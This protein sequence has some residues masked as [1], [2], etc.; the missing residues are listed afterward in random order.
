MH[1]GNFNSYAPTLTGT[2]ASGNWPINSVNVTGTVAMGNGGTGLTS[3]GTAGNVLTSVGG[4]WASAA[5]TGGGATG[6][7]GGALAGTYPNPTMGVNPNYYVTAGNGYG[8]EF[9]NSASY[10][11]T[12]GNGTNYQYGPVTDYSINTSMNSGSPGRGFT[13]GVY[14]TAP[15]AALSEGGNFQVAGTITAGGAISAAIDN[16][17]TWGNTGVRTEVRNDAG[18]SGAGIYSGFFNT[19]AP[20]PAGDWPPGASSWWHLLDVRHQN[21]AN[22]YAMQFA[23]G[24]FDQNLWF[25]KTN[26]SA[27]SAWSQ[28]LVGH[29]TQIYTVNPAC[30]NYNQNFEMANGNGS[31]QCISWN[32]YAGYY[33]CFSTTW[34]GSVSFNTQATNPGENSAYVLTT[35][36]TCPEAACSGNQYEP[37]CGQSAC[38]T[39]NFM[40]NGC[41]GNTGSSCATSPPNCTNTSQG[42]TAN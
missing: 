1:N 20:S 40:G 14:N 36:S 18:A 32:N 41:G 4:V 28:V 12:M 15:T 39:T 19:S 21:T 35:Y 2:G 42:W 9:W 7:A 10:A 30:S 37:T 34:H 16:G 13:W 25:R 6:P 3:A 11:I 38:T 31:L 5:P 27:S 23:G 22:N 8:V 29:N 33:Y 26:N 17:V 24:F